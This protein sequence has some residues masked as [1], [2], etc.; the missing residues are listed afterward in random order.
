MGSF[1]IGVS[2]DGE[3]SDRDVF[4]WGEFSDG[5]VFR[6]GSFQME[7]SSDG[8]VFRRGC[9]QMGEL[10]DRGVFRWGVFR[11]PPPAWSGRLNHEDD[12]DLHPSHDG[13]YAAESLQTLFPFLPLVMLSILHDGGG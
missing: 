7:V 1:Q 10:S 13:L 4:R 8:G 12:S 3:L 6:W 2:S 11:W 9:L 5:D